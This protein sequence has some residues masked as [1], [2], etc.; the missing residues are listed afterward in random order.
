MSISP[1]LRFH[2]Q[3]IDDPDEAWENI[4]FV[5]RKHKIIQAH[6]IE[7]QILTLSPIEFSC[8]EDYL[9]KFKTLIILCAKCNIKLEEERCI[10]IILAKLGSAYL[11]FVSIVYA[12]REALETYYKNI[13]LESFCDALIREQDKLVQ[14][15][16]INI[17]CN[18]NKKINP[19]IPKN[20]ILATTTRKTRVPIPLS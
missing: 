12:T 18:S 2:L 8:I 11:V 9:S 17:A 19:R 7:N 5:F 1:D 15:G 10:Y 3:G 6:Q 13:S 14:L 4:Q 16:V 20:N